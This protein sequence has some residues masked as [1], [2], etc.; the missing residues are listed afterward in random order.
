MADQFLQN[1]MHS[2][3]L[4]DIDPNIEFLN[5]IPGPNPFFSSP[6]GFSSDSNLFPQLISEGPDQ[7]LEN[8]P[9]LF[10]IPDEITAVTSFTEPVNSNVDRKDL[11]RKTPATDTPQSS[12][13]KN[14]A[15]TKRAGKRKKVKVE[16]TEEDEKP[17]EVVHVRAKRGQATYSH[18]LAE[19]VRRRKINERFRCLKDIVPGCYKTMGMA[20]MLDEIISYVQSLQGQVEFLSMRLST[21]TSTYYNSSTDTDVMAT[22]MQSNV[23]IQGLD[24]AQF[25]QLG[26]DFN[27]FPQ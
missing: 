12:Y 5:Q 6:I 16:N 9:G 10:T 14:S 20:V 3:S 19:R 11:K 8:F 27:Y 25:A 1:I 17:R 7:N 13:A 24:S 4:P 21:A 26:L 23:A 18:S 15:Y 2:F 22:I